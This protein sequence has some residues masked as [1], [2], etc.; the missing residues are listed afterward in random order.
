MQI[1]PQTMSI[2]VGSA[3][4]NARCPFCV[5][6]MTP[7]NGVA[8]KADAINYRNWD[9][10]CQL[11]KDSGVTTILL[12]GKGEPTLF[13]DQVTEVLEQLRPYKFPIIELQTNAIPI[14]TGAITDGML[15][16]WH[17]LG[18][19]MI[20]ISNVGIDYE[21]NNKIYTP[22]HKYINLMDVIRRIHSFGFSVR[23]ATVMI[24]GGV[25]SPAKIDELLSFAAAL[26]VEQTTIRPV[27]RADVTV[28]Q[29]EAT[30]DQ[31]YILSLKILNEDQGANDAAEW[32]QN[33]AVTPKQIQDVHE[34]IAN[35]G[36][37]LRRLP[38]GA[39]VYDLY[40][41][42]ICLTNCL[43][44]EPLQPEIRQLIYFPDGHLR[45]DWEKS[46]AIIL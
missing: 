5:S 13:P 38:H 18:L 36:T 9:Q 26:D 43:T 21:L 16:M 30:H 29:N 22:R 28:R 19:R 24:K 32:V 7:P 44:R 8:I 2:V 45:Y 39:E 3:V 10:A 4:C 14:A 27:T 6:K 40:G 33:N 34:Y 25:D 15:Q 31:K 11:A 20:A 42:N 12:T 35:A 23:M 17:R 46:G 37:L 1:K 41:H